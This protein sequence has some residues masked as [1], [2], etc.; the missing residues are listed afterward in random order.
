MIVSYSAPSLYNAI[1]KYPISSRIS[2]NG[3]PLCNISNTA[4]FH[5]IP[6]VSL[7]LRFLPDLA[8]ILFIIS[9][10]I[11]DIL[12]C[13][14]QRF[15]SVCQAVSRVPLFDSPVARTG[16]SLIPPEPGQQHNS[17]GQHTD[18]VVKNKEYHDIFQTYNNLFSL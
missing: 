14:Y 9:A 8:K 2:K 7:L 10:F 11:V 13:F 17:H 16:F 18:L 4:T 6:E 1:L 5:S 15:S 12:F 3:V